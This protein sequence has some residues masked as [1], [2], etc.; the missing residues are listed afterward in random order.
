MPLELHEDAFGDA[1]NAQALAVAADLAYFS[2][3]EGAP[4][5]REHLG[6][7]A[8]LFS[9]GNTQVYLAQNDQHLVVAF[10]G[11]ESPNAMEGLKDWLLTNAANFLMV[12]EGRLGTDLAAAGVGARFHQGFVNAIADVWDA[13]LEAVVAERKRL[14]RPLWVTG[15]SLGGALAML[16]GWLFYRK[17]VPVHQIYTFGA[18]MIGNDEAA[19]AFNKA[20]AG[21][22]FRYVDTV[23]PVPRLPTISLASNSYVHCD[24]E[25]G[26]GTP[27]GKVA[28]LEW[29]ASLGSK[30]VNGLLNATLIDDIWKA[31][32]SRIDAHLMTNYRKR[33]PGA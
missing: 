14:D 4:A 29:L 6:M 25:V 5:Y 33:I 23:D 31:V 17:F 7:D 26:L 16:A 32:L 18:P 11:T 12:P 9:A 19:K 8:R 15:H 21:K 28:A 30:T 20:F 27:E 22:I 1:R 3:A 13:L 10:R 24:K 2:Q